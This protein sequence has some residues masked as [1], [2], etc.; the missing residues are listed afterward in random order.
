MKRI[1]KFIVAVFVMGL[2]LSLMTVTAFAAVT[3]SSE[4]GLQDVI[5]DLD[6]GEEVTIISSGNLVLE[7]GLEIDDP[8]TIHFKN[9]TFTQESEFEEAAIYVESDDVTLD[10]TGCTFD[11]IKCREQSPIY[12]KGKNCTVK[13]GTF[14]GC[15]NY[16]GDGGAIYIEGDNGTIVGCAFNNCSTVKDE[17]EDG[18][19]IY[20]DGERC[21][22]SGCTFFYCES[23]NDGGAICVN[24]DE[25]SIENC[26]FTGCAAHDDG[27]A[28]YVCTWVEYTYITNCTFTDCV[29]KH[30]HSRFDTI[31]YGLIFSCSDTCSEIAF[32][33]CTFNT[34]ASYEDNIDTVG[35]TSIKNCN[36]FNNDVSVSTDY[37]RGISNTGSVLSAGNVV[38]ICVVAAAA[39]AGVAAAVVVSK[40]KK[41]TAEN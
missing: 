13:G 39:V 7:E 4:E 19:A 12:I 41:A 23:Y 6:D 32:E 18:G 30:N 11:S 26:D 3:V 9:I 31:C 29:T 36:K 16:E 20:L 24:H 27:G 15:C 10:F 38:I 2:L 1:S 28:I 35:S 5:D 37:R 33:G 34:E 22:V 40:K 21:L 8:C 17:G 14:N 25:C